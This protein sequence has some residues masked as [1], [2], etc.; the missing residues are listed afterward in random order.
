MT[1]V[2]EVWAIPKKEH[3]LKPL[4]FRLLAIFS[5]LYRVETGAWYA[6]IFDWLRS[7]LH[8]AVI[9]AIPGQEALDVAWM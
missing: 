2:G 4:D 1:T 5:A 3:S 7:I 6:I 8:P 9:G